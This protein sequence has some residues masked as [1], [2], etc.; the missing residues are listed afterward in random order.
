MLQKPILL[1]LMLPGVFFKSRIASKVKDGRPVYSVSEVEITDFM[2]AV[3]ETNFLYSF[4]LSALSALATGLSSLD[5]VNEDSINLILISFIYS[6]YGVIISVYLYGRKTKL[7]DHSALNRDT[8]IFKST[9]SSAS[10]YS[11]RSSI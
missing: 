9:T 5:N 6:I 10:A 4:T 1:P 11:V 2:L 7:A 8:V 3:Q